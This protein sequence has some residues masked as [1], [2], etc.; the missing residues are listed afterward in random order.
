MEKASDA[1]IVELALVWGGLGAWNA[2]SRHH[3]ED[4][5]ENVV[6]APHAGIEPGAASWQPTGPLI[7]TLGVKDLIVV[8]T[9]DATLICDRSRAA[10]VKALVDLLR[11]RG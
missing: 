1:V 3:A 11:A 8:R 9:P 10:E 5:Q 2:L 6:M 7:A 4:G